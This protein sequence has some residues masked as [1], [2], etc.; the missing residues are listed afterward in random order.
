MREGVP[1]F[2]MVVLFPLITQ[3]SP[4][5]LELFILSASLVPEPRVACTLRARHMDLVPLPM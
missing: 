4:S 2:D 1:T 5:D 3:P